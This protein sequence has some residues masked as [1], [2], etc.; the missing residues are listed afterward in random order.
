MT[1]NSIIPNFGPLECDQTLN[2]KESTVRYYPVSRIVTNEYGWFIG[3]GKWNEK[4]QILK[5]R[6]TYHE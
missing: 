3:W 5:I 4:D 6:H 2:I 1:C